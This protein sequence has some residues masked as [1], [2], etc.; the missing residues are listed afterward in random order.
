[1]DLQRFAVI[2]ARI[3]FAGKMRRLGGSLM[4]QPLNNSCHVIIIVLRLYME[5]EHQGINLLHAVD[6]H[7]VAVF[8]SPMRCPAKMRSSCM[9]QHLKPFLHIN[10]QKYG[11]FK[12]L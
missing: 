5:S 9:I 12:A 8:V 6:L 3:R 7:R 1:V 4:S 11:C 10:M 2:V